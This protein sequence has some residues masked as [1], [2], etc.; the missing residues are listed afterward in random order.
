ML[1]ELIV[2]QGPVGS[3]VLLLQIGSL[4]RPTGVD[5]INQITF[6][7]KKDY[8]G[9]RQCC[10]LKSVGVKLELSLLLSKNFDFDSA[11]L[12]YAFLVDASG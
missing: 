5:Q 1:G 11:N 12:G 8:L 4:I 9:L 3:I 2:R 6:Q 10:F 7:L